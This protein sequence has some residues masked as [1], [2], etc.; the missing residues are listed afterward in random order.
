MIASLHGTLGSLGSDSAIIDVGGVG[1]R[2]YMPTSTL[3][4]LGAAGEEVKLHTHLYLREDNATLYGFASA[5]ELGLFQTLISV[6]GLYLSVVADIGILLAD[7]FFA[8]S[9][10]RAGL[11]LASVLVGLNARLIKSA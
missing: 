6:S 9:R 1:F 2:V 3:S 8:F 4:T 5:E 11:T 10:S 7:S